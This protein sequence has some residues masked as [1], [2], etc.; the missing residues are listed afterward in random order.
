MILQVT[1]DEDKAKSFLAFL[2]DLDFVKVK[3]LSSPKKK[4]AVKPKI[5]E[6]PAEPKFAY[7]GSCPDW[8]IDAAELR[9]TSN[10]RKAQW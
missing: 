9:A 7:F 10:R 4:E 1:V 8:D 3:P 2:K 6:K 5:E